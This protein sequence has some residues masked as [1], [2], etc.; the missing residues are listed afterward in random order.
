MSREI[1]KKKLTFLDCVICIALVLLIVVSFLL[2]FKSS[3]GS[4]NT[5]TVHTKDE[6][7]TVD[8]DKDSTFSFISGDYSFTAEVKDGEI[9]VIE[10]DCPDK[11]CAETPAIGKKPGVIVCV[12]ARMYIECGEEVT[13]NEDADVIV[14]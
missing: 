4:T 12:P 7:F 1:P 2:L 11:I 13:G 5:A 10:A 3:K 14:P 8:L 6:V 9:S